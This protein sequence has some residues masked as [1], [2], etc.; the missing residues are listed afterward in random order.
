MSIA[1]YNGRFCETGEIGI[2]LTDR[3]IFFGDGIYD[4]AVGRNGGIY[5]EREHITRFFSNAA[6]LDL[7]P[8][9]DEEGL[10]ALLREITERNGFKGY[11]IYFQLT[12]C[13]AERTHSYGG[14]EKA[15]L[16]ITVREHSL[17]DAR[18]RLKLITAED[19]RYYMCNIKTLNLLPAVLASKKAELSGCDEAVFL[20]NGVVT[21]CAHSNIA[22]IKNG[23]LYTHPN[24]RLILPGITRRR[25]LDLCCDMGIHCAEVPF[26]RD[27]LMS[28]DD[29]LITSTSKLCMRASEID[30]EAVGGEG[31]KLGNRII[32]AVREDFCYSQ[33]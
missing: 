10:S 27:M 20:R 7:T 30:G 18:E 22:V 14:N 19:L 26:D 17:P 1:Y 32:D 31:N 13:S 9:T 23:V 6:A 21:E 2:P 4:A 28:A 29:V 3:S 16:L 15:N 24:G 25:M 5:S 12:R 8:P 11:F 33:R